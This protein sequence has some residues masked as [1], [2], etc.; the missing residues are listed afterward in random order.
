LP[1][2]HWVADLLAPGLR[3]VLCGTALGPESARQRAY[4]ADPGNR[5]W[6]TLHA[7]GLT[8]ERFRSTDYPRLLDLGIGLTDLCKHHYGTDARLPADAFDREGLRQRIAAVAPAILAFTSKEGAKR[9]FG[10]PTGRIAYGFQSERIGPTRI[11]VLPSPSGLARRYW[12]DAPWNAL[13]AAVRAPA[14]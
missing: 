8:P 11:F 2:D 5:F 3:L 4:Y 10:R 9:Y 13:A 6:P 12:T 7:V 14:G 1:A